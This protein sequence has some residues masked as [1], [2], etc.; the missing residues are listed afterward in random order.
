MSNV[1][2]DDEAQKRGVVGCAY[3]VGCDLNPDLQRIRKVANLRNALPVRIVSLHVCYNNPRMIPVFSMAVLVMGTHTRVRFR[4][5]YGSNEECQCQLSSF[6]I[7]IS[8]L[9]VSPRG[10]FNL[11]NHR[12]F[13]AMQRAIEATKCKRTGP[14]LPVAQKAKKKLDEKDLS[15]QPIIKDDVLLTAPQPNQPNINKLTGYGEGLIGFLPT[16]P[17]FACPWWS[18]VEEATNLTPMAPPQSQLSVAYHQSHITRPAPVKLSK[19]P[20]KPYVILDPCPNDILFGRGK[21]IQG[22]PANVRFREI[23]LDK[24]MDKYYDKGGK[25]DKGVV[26]TYVV[27]LVKE[28]GGRFLKELEN[29]GWVEVDEAI[30]LE[31]K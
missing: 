27:H 9:P 30:Q 25:G 4:A 5:H 28:E 24:H 13:M 31:R 11:G 1:E 7:P 19:S 12:T 16:L 10:E 26:A 21:P 6:G 17:S 8:A 18:V 29:G 15:R 20:A 23:T 2:D 3:L 14:L 22:R